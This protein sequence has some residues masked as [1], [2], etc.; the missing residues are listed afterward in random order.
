MQPEII[1]RL[2]RVDNGLL[3]INPVKTLT[4]H[5]TACLVL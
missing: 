1:E 5:T 4:R 2:L 3:T